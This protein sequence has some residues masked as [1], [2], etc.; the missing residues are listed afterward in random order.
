[1]SIQHVH[2]LYRVSIFQPTLAFSLQA[3]FYFQWEFR[4]VSSSK[5][6]KKFNQ[7]FKI[8][9]IYVFEKIIFRRIFYEPL[10]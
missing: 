10:S 4:E 1:M 7:N 3:K 6:K 2:E 5:K 8:D 9:T